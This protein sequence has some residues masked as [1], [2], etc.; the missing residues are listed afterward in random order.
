VS[1]LDGTCVLR[2]LVQLPSR[3]CRSS[4]GPA[5]AIP[6]SAVGQC[7]FWEDLSHRGENWLFDPYRKDADWWQYIDIRLLSSCAPS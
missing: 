3:S 2:N 7:R 4:S 6:E 1:A 5:E